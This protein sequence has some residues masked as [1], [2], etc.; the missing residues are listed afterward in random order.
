MEEELQHEKKCTA[1]TKTKK[2]KK[3]NMENFGVVD[4][5]INYK[6]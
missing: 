5:I 2:K 4:V 6:I 1:K 3:Q